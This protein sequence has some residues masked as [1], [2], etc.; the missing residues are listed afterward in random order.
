MS[1]RKRWMVI[2]DGDSVHWVSSTRDIYGEYYPTKKLAKEAFIR[3]CVE[4][5][6]TSLE[7]LAQNKSQLEQAQQ[8]KIRINV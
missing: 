5:M 1:K 6:N 8:L 3:E 4:R 2:T 7:H